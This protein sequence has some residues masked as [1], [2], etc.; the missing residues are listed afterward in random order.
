MLIRIF[1]QN[2]PLTPIL[3]IGFGLLLWADGF[4]FYNKVSLVVDDPAPLYGLLASLLE[5]MPLLSLVVAFTL[6]LLQV[7]IVNYI[8]QANSLLSRPS[9]LPGFLYLVMMSS[10]PH[11]IS[12]H[13]LLPAN[14]FLLIALARALLAYSEG[15]VML[16]V[17]NVG[18]LIA[19]AGL[20]YYPAL[21]FFL[22][23]IVVM[24]IY[25]LLHLRG[26]AAAIMGFLTPFFFLLTYF[27]LSDQLEGRLEQMLAQYDPLLILEQSYSPFSTM[28]IVF[29]GLLSFLAFMKLTMV[30]ITDKPVRIRKRFRVL[31]Y[32]FVFSLLSVLVVTDYFEVHHGLMMIPLSVV[33]S[34]FFIEMKRKW[35]AEVVFYLFLALVIAGKVIELV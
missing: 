13:P 14:L 12:L 3:L 33:L 16:E 22:W 7:F 24:G 15:E 27:Y 18:F 9:W 4:I 10:D 25:F 28:M 20:F 6:L 31:I 11:L 32:F 5:G 21:L 8:A 23:L 35:L 26:L 34:V 1:K 17:F 29:L 30:F 19:L 2:T